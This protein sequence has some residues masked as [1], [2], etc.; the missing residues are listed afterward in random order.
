MEEEKRKAGKKEAAETTA[1]DP[2]SPKRTETPSH[3]VQLMVRQVSLAKE[4]VM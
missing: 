4:D 3:R 2:P 1:T